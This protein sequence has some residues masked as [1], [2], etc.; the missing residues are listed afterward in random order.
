MC[1]S[2]YSKR[3][4]VGCPAAKKL[5]SRIL[6]NLASVMYKRQINFYLPSKRWSPFQFLKGSMIVDVKRFCQLTMSL[7]NSVRTLVKV[8]SDPVWQILSCRYKNRYGPLLY[9]DFG[10]IMV[11]KIVTERRLIGKRI[12]ILEALLNQ[13]VVFITS[14]H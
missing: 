7:Q 8:R 4:N 5:I 1:L 12:A 3:L 13:P 10:C 2:S 14:R 11:S 6:P 9:E